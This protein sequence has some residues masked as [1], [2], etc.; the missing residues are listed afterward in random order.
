MQRRSVGGECQN[1]G[2]APTLAV[3]KMATHGN[4]VSM[5]HGKFLSAEEASVFH[6]KDCTA[7]IGK[8]FP[9]KTI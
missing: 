9:Q 5:R 3:K 6:P 8:S 1:A 4:T 7:T 2:K